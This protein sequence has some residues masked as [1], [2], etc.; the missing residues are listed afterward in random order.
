MEY[1]PAIFTEAMS[2]THHLFQNQAH[3]YFLQTL[4]KYSLQ[5]NTNSD[6]N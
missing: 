3:Q 5:E 4:Y 6:P 1:L 2:I